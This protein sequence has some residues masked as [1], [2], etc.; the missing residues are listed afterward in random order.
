[1][2]KPI[3]IGTENDGQN[4]LVGDMNTVVQTIQ[5]ESLNRLLAVTSQQGV[6]TGL[7]VT[8]VGT[9]GNLILEVSAGVGYTPSGER[10]ELLS[11]TQINVGSDLNK[12]L[13]LRQTTAADTPVA[14]PVSGALIDTREHNVSTLA[15]INVAP[16]DPGRSDDDIYLC[17]ITGINSPDPGDVAFDDDPPN[18]EYL[19]ARIAPLQITDDQ[20]NQDSDGIA[21]GAAETLTFTAPTKVFNHHLHLG[22]GTQTAQNIHALKL[23]D[24]SDPDGLLS[25]GPRHQL[26]MHSNGVTGRDAGTFT[27]CTPSALGTQ[28]LLQALANPAYDQLFIGGKR[29]TTLLTLSPAY[30]DFALVPPVV[31]KYILMGLDLDNSSNLRWFTHVRA[32]AGATLNIPGVY[33]WWVSQDAGT[34]NKVLNYYYHAGAP[35]L[36]W[37]DGPEVAVTSSSLQQTIYRLPGKNQGYIDVMVT[38]TLPSGD[39]NDI[40]TIAAMPDPAIWSTTFLICS[41]FIN[42]AGVILPAVPGI[43]AI[44]DLR[45]KGTLN[46]RQIASDVLDFET[47][48]PTAKQPKLGLV[49]ETTFNCVVHG[50]LVTWSSGLSLHVSAGV[51]W[52]MGRRYTFPYTVVNSPGGG[53]A[54]CTICYDARTE[55]VVAKSD[56]Y[57]LPERRWMVPLAEDTLNGGYFQS[58]TLLDIRPLMGVAPWG[59][60]GMGHFTR[61]HCQDYDK[62]GG[63]SPVLLGQIVDTEN[64]LNGAV[65]GQLTPPL[66][67]GA[68]GKIALGTIRGQSASSGSASMTGNIGL[69]TVTGEGSPIAPIPGNIA[70]LSITGD[71]IANGSIDYQAKL[72]N[73]PLMS[74]PFDPCW[75]PPTGWIYVTRNHAAYVISHNLGRVPKFVTIFISNVNNPTDFSQV[76]IVTQHVTWLGGGAQQEDGL[77]VKGLTSNSITIQP[78]RTAVFIELTNTGGEFDFIRWDD[79]HIKI[80]VV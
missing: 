35:T 74:T 50:G 29:F 45:S 27:A 58:A 25:A 2:D 64:I 32:S 49:R 16:D 11:G 66:T 33:L 76:K 31:Y 46:W 38:G 22:T 53:S 23:T 67:P 72:Y 24:L 48:Q 80:A 41:V 57:N 17:Q 65:T 1:M 6:V 52:V 14:L 68:A 77:M 7:A 71:N 40:Y 34:G 44:N 47:Y 42:P 19:G 5:D 55:S 18:R 3:F 30:Y 63:G 54:V 75:A 28:L 8:T 69:R 56:F 39:K 60:D 61:L 51:V 70:L 43:P 79:G 36:Q 12:W 73:Q 26:E 15:I 4:V 20:F 78:G 21:L 62:A 59:S 13:V 9:P 10:M 37:D